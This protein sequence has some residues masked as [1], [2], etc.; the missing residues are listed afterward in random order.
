MKITILIILA[1][2]LV[3]PILA[4][5]VS[6]TWK[7]TMD[8]PMG[9]MEN[10]IILKVDGSNLNG[11]VKTDFFE[12]KI[13]NAKIDGNNISFEIT[14]DF[15]KLVYAGA[16]QADQLKFDVTGPDGNKTPLICK[17]QP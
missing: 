1:I 10:T 5:D 7:G 11:T 8:T 15:G 9:A 13:E 14:L 17:R 3:P 6:G 4:A 12:S 16:L 2:S